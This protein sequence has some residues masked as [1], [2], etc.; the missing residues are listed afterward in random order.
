MILLQPIV[1][2]RLAKAE[3]HSTH[4]RVVLLGT[5]LITIYSGYFGAGAGVLLVSLYATML[6]GGMQRANAIKSIMALASNLAAAVYFA[7]AAPVDWSAAA[8]LAPASFLGAVIGVRIAKRL[9]DELLRIVVAVG[10]VSAA[11]YALY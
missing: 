2:K 4:L 3:A 9:P 7:F 5:F 10:G 8:L 6:A 1:V 11:L